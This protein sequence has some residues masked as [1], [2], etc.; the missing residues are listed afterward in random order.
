MNI[1]ETETKKTTKSTKSKS[2]KKVEDTNVEKLDLQN[3]DDKEL[4]E[5]INVKINSEISNEEDSNNLEISELNI[6]SEEDCLCKY[7]EIIQ[8]LTILS[9]LSLKN[10]NLSKDFIT[11]VNKNINSIN[12][13]ALKITSD[14]L[15]YM[16]KE[17]SISLK[18]KDAKSKKEKKKGPKENYS[19]N[20]EK[21]TFI[22][23]LNFMKLEENSCVSRGQLIQHINA[24]VKKEKT[25]NNP[26]IFVEG[27][28][29]KFYLIGDL[30][31]LFDF[32]KNQMIL[33]ED[34]NE[35]NSFENI[36]SYN[37]IMKY[38][39]YCFPVESKNT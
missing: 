25:N 2:T 27:D 33:R 37:Q 32:I 3:T 17:N 7:K 14:T 10:F 23:V 18:N 28:N 26:D 24:F 30:K 4:D 16:T 34:L 31:V 6:I 15:D 19:I 21:P 29:R 36:L 9:K 1:V 38:L 12:K 22:E 35:S 11:Q 5:E 39:K 8:N 20:K 13:L